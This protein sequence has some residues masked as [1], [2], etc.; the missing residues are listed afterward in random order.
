ML[1]LETGGWLETERSNYLA[2]TLDGAQRYTHTPRVTTTTATD[3]RPTLTAAQEKAMDFLTAEGTV[4]SGKNIGRKGNQVRV[5]PSTLLRL[6]RM[7]L[8]VIEREIEQ[9]CLMGAEWSVAAAQGGPVQNQKWPS[10]VFSAAEY[11]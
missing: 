10:A 9:Q 2:V 8:V 1:A 6:E 7:G 4:F 11:Q 3:T 5:S